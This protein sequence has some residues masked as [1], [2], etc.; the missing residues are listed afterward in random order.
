[1]QITSRQIETFYAVVSI[2][3]M[4]GAARFLGRTQSAVSRL[5]SDLEGSTGLILFERSGARLYPT[6]AGLSMY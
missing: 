2:G 6:Q 1:M 4:T 3:S 5:I